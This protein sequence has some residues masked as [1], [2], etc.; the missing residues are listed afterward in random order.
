MY[1]P[2]SIDSMHFCSRQGNEQASPS[3]CPKLGEPL[4]A[5]KPRV[6]QG[7]PSC[8]QELPRQPSA[9]CQGAHPAAGFSTF[10]LRTPGSRR[11]G[12]LPYPPQ[13][14]HRGITGAPG[15]S[16]GGRFP[17]REGHLLHF[18]RNGRGPHLEGRQE[19]Q[20]SSPFPLRPQGPCRVGMRFFLFLT[21]FTPYDRLW[22]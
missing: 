15:R 18:L 3:Q 6:T 5:A 21:Y 7:S 2:F 17:G 13:L 1:P 20:A 16:P 4:R 14:A 10:F 19:P 9:V 8:C 22:G 11:P 12:S